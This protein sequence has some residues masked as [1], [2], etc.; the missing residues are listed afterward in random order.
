MKKTI[1]LASLLALVGLVPIS[2]G[3]ID[4]TEHSKPELTVCGGKILAPAVVAGGKTLTGAE[5]LPYFEICVNGKT[6]NSLSPIWKSVE[7]Q[8]SVLQNGGT[9]RTYH[10]KAKKILRG[11]NVYIDRESFP[12]SKL[13]RERMRLQADKPGMRLTDLD[14]KNHLIFPQYSFRADKDITAEEIR[15]GRF[16][17][18]TDLKNNHMFHPDRFP[19]KVGNDV[20]E[21]KGPF[22]VCDLGDHKLVTAYEHASQDNTFM[23]EKNVKKNTGN[24]LQ[25]GVEG[26]QGIIKDDDLWFIGTGICR[27]EAGNLEIYNRIRRGGYIDG[28]QI[29]TEG[30]YE[31][32]WSML[33]VIDDDESVSDAIQ[34]YLYSRIT[35]HSASRRPVFYYNTWGMQRDMPK[36]QLRS[37]LT[38]ERLAKDIQYCKEMG[39]ERFILD[40][41]WQTSFGLWKADPKKFPEGLGKVVKM[42]NDAG[43]EAGVW[44]SLL[45]VAKDSDLQ[46]QHPEWRI[47]DKYGAPLLVQWGNPGFDIESG[48]YHVLLDALKALVDQGVRFFKWDAVSTMSSTNAGLDHGGEDATPKERM[49]RYNY[50]FPFYVTRLARDLKEYNHDVVVELDLTE[51]WRCMIGLMTLEESKFFWINNGASR[52][53]DYSTYRTKSIRAGLNEFSG[54]FPPEVFT[55]AVYPMDISGALRYNVNSILMAGHGFWGNLD[56]T[57]ES[58]RAY[59]RSQLDKAKKVLPYT[60]G[61]PMKSTGVMAGTPEIYSQTNTDEGY[62]LVTAFSSEPWKGSY[63]VALSPSKVMAVLGASYNCTEDGLDIDFDLAGKDATAAA[64]V[65]GEEPGS[66]RIISSTCALEDIRKDGRC[67]SVLPSADGAVKVCFP[68]SGETAEIAVTGGQ[69]TDINARVL[70]ETESF[71][72]P[73]GWVRDHQAFEKIGSA[74][75]MAHGLGTPVEDASTTVRFDHAGIYHVYVSTYNWTS[76]WYDQEGPG[77]FQVAV[78]GATLPNVLGKTGNSWEW[79]YAGQVEIGRGDVEVALKDLTGFNGRADAIYFS[80]EK[81]APAADYKQMSAIRKELLGYEE[82]TTAECADLVV[83]GGGIAGCTAA[84]TAARYGLKVTLVDN[85]PWLGGNAVLGVRTDGAAFKNLYPALGYA[86][87]EMTGLRK[88]LKNDPEAYS[89]N[90]KNGT[91]GAKPQ[92]YGTSASKPAEDRESDILTALRRIE[93]QGDTVH[94]KQEVEFLEAEY[95]RQNAAQDRERI[96]REAGVTIYHNIHVYD[97]CKQDGRICSVTGRDLRTGEDIVFSGTLF[98]DCTGDG[99]VGYLA[100][101][102]YRIGREARAVAGEPSAPETEDQK[103]M[104]ASMAWAAYPRSD[105]GSFPTWE[106]I[107]WAFKLDKEYHIDRNQWNWWWET[108]LEIDNATDAE[109]VRDNFLRA[110][111]GNWA[112]LKNCE[113]KYADYRLDY[114]DHIAM[115]RESRRL[116]GDVIV[117]E[118][119]IRTK[120]VFPDAS[121][122][123]TWT[124]D[125][126][127]AKPD[128]AQRFP[129][130]EWTT[131]ST[132]HKPEAFVG[133]YDLPYRA[134]YSR[135][136]DNLFIG[137]RNMSVTHLALGT[138]RVQLTL[139]MAAEVIGMAA[140]I[141]KQHGSDPRSVYTDHLEELKQ[142]MT[143]G[144]PHE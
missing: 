40:D 75:M 25:Q 103:K 57:T 78:D 13:I 141:C 23:N 63:T 126:H 117:N 56:K 21:V 53:G 58:D 54:I 44:L 36:D 113:P 27:T 28:E 82:A 124:M 29:P 34:D 81:K 133:K 61:W 120:K 18:K 79:Q 32:V 115:K 71:K 4:E 130:W 41:G 122:T 51:H 119:D 15:I 14:G 123:S 39:I 55:Y 94:D 7:E 12:S 24:D 66:P 143:E 118:N 125:L 140:A 96:L 111:F 72:H 116:L 137:G 98:A 106:E 134:L 136:V 38:E 135:N 139:G 87:C 109:L 68:G 62:S 114:L 60:Q 132:N 84:L 46:E 129:G 45:A 64:F 110:V 67:L 37:C 128:N 59:V 74:Y 127:F 144:V 99:T 108:G 77:A 47:N 10:F 5:E 73:G 35:D 31:T 138:V 30:F 22:V 131:N 101:A 100:G 92:S 42:I 90:K 1:L 43:M 88:E 49:D 83:V 95:K 19:V 121:F 70:V 76:P 11:L 107:P 97:V 20:S 142:H 104:G 9:V 89:I 26:D 17:T 16:Q 52:Y 33:T 8:T 80:T 69:W 93:A 112:Y 48:F 2:A 50:L 85:L 91:G 65:L 3:V 86:A 105:A 6:V 102:D